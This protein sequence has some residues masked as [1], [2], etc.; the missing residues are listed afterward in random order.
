VPG[1]AI[2]GIARIRS[3]DMAAQQYLSYNLPDGCNFGCLIDKY[4]GASA[5]R[6]R[7]HRLEHV[8]VVAD[9]AGRGE[10]V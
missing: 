5:V 10:C 6:G 4:E 7:E 3:E 8:S 9:G 1:I 2:V